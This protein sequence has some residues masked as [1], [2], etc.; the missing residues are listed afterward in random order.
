MPHRHLALACALLITAA[1]SLARAYCRTTTCPSCELDP[2]T[3]CPTG[4]VPIAWPGLCVSY[5]V[6]R[7]ASRQ[8]SLDDF[9]RTADTA[10]TTWRDAPCPGGGSPSILPS[11]AFGTTSCNLHEYNGAEPNANIIVVR[12]DAWPYSTET[13]ALA[14][15]SITFDTASGE[16]YDVDMEINGQ[17]PLFVGDVVPPTSYDL[18]SILTHEAG[19]FFGLS[20]SPDPRATMFSRYTAGS[21]S[22]RVLGDDD[23]QGICAV[24]PPARTATA[25]SYAPKHGFSPECSMLVDAAGTCSVGAAGRAA[26]PGAWCGSVAVL[27]AGLRRRRRAML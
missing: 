26:T 9:V 12:D 22:L 24:Y 18:Q 2:V 23:I 5:S 7:H 27:A 3:Q 10:F 13:N 17:Q 20:H 8:V 1:P 21:T 25:C 19:H 6:S 4:G 11:A 15:T 16:I 14:I